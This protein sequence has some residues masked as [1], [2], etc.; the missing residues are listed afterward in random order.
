VKLLD[1]VTSGL[2]NTPFVVVLVG[3]SLQEGSP[4]LLPPP[5]S[6]LVCLLLPALD[7]SLLPSLPSPLFPPAPLLPMP[8]TLV[9][10]SSLVPHVASRRVWQSQHA[11]TARRHSTPPHQEDAVIHR[12]QISRHEAIS[13]TNRRKGLSIRPIPVSVHAHLLLDFLLDAL[14][15]HDYS[16]YPLRPL[17]S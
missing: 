12:E 4:T 2:A 1:K 6:L 9:F 11:A 5:L 7:P 15:D 3:P 16:Y 17:P 14:P 8:S 13:C 10:P